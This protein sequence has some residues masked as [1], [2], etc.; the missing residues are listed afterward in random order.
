MSIISQFAK[1][2]TIQRQKQLAFIKLNAARIFNNSLCA[3][4]ECLRQ[5]N[6]LEFVDI[7]QTHLCTHMQ[8]MRITHVFE[9][10]F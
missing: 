5:I 9:Y 6:I 4:A 7:H 3:N 1:F 2:K 8:F 10:R